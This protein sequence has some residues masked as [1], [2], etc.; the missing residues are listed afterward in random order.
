MFWHV[1]PDIAGVPVAQLPKTN[2]PPEELQSAW[3][4]LTAKDIRKVLELS[5]RLSSEA[6]DAQPCNAPDLA[7]KV[8]QGQ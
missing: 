3:C 8:A 7:R 2:T 6:N 4:E 1:F 5:I